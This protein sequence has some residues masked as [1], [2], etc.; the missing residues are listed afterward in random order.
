MTNV[1]FKSGMLK[2]HSFFRIWPRN[3]RNQ[4]LEPKSF[5]QPSG[6]GFATKKSGEFDGD[7]E[8]TAA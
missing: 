7:G 4:K 8:A 3:T 6:V 5:T 2:A 1:C